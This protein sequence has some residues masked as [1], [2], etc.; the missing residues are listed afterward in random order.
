M[1]VKSSTELEIT[2]SPLTE[3]GKYRPILSYEVICRSI[4]LDIDRR[5]REITEKH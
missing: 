3:H 2:S 4:Q 1:Y 5:H